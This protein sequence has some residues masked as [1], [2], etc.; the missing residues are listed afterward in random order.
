MM[1]L[2]ANAETRGAGEERDSKVTGICARV[3]QA[4]SL[5]VNIVCALLLIELGD[6]RR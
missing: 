5:N 2:T 3:I 1:T 4:L 6:C